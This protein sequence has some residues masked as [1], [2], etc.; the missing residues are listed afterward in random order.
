MTVTVTERPLALTWLAEYAVYGRVD[1]AI[2]AADRFEQRMLALAF[3]IAC[4]ELVPECGEYNSQTRLLTLES[5][6]RVWFDAGT[7]RLKRGEFHGVVFDRRRDFSRG[8]VLLAESRVRLP[9]AL[10]VRFLNA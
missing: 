4:D 5:G 6:S 8:D 7:E 9:N 2:V 10:G 3:A 1:L